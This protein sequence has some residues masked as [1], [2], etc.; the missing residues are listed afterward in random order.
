MSSPG[1]PVTIELAEIPHIR[2]E[3]ERVKAFFSR[4]VDQL[5]HMR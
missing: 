1:L 2:R 5:P 3:T 4:R